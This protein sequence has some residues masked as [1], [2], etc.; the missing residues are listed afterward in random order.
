MCSLRISEALRTSAPEGTLAAF[1]ESTRAVAETV[2]LARELGAAVTERARNAQVAL[3]GMLERVVEDQLIDIEVMRLAHRQIADLAVM[4]GRAA[5]ARDDLMRW[6]TLRRGITDA[7]TDGLAPILNAYDEANEPYLGLED[8]YDRVLY[9]SLARRVL[10]INPGL[11]ETSALSL[12]D[13]RTRFRDLDERIMAMRRQALI[14]DLAAI[15]IPQGIQ[16]PRKGECT[17]AMLIQNEIAKKKN[18]IPIRDLIERAAKAI[19]AMKPCTMMSPA[20]VAQ[21]LKPG[22][23]FD[24]VVIDEASQMRP[25]EAIWLSPVLARQ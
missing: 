25:E 12:D 6:V 15:P 8:A 10:E 3:R 16:S 2:G 18:H 1:T 24:L 22:Q 17:E 13:I 14:S 7:R 21:F 19:S 23:S 4:F 5:R 20:S 11:G 9:R